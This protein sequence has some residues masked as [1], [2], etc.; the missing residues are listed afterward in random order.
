[1]QIRNP[2]TGE[3]DFELE[4]CSTELIHKKAALLRASQPEWERATVQ[5]RIAVLSDFAAALGDARATLIDALVT[6]TGRYHESVLEVD[7]VINNIKRWCGDAAVLLSMPPARAGQIPF[8][9]ITQSYLPYQ[10]VGV[11]S[12]WNFP[13]LLSMVDTIPALLAGCSVLLKPSEVTS[14]FVSPFRQVLASVPA[15]HRVFDVVTGTGETGQALIDTVDVTCFTGSVT[16]GRK[17]AQRCAQRFIPAFLELGGK[18]PAIVCEDADLDVAASALCW[19]SMVNAGQSCMS[20]ERV[21]VH[22]KV[23]EV[24]IE[25]LTNCVQNLKHN[26]PDVTAGHIG[27]IIS[28]AQIDIV[29]GQLADAKEKGAKV[30]CGGEVV[31]LGGGAYCQPTLLHNVTDEMKVLK[32]ETFAAILP[33][34]VVTSDAQAVQKANDTEYGL[35]AAVFSRNLDRAYSIASQLH[36]GAVSINDASLTALVH[37][38][39]KQSFKLSG[40]GGSRMGKDAIMR[41]VRKKAFIRNTGTPSPWWF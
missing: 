2:R 18:D 20:L 34:V 10:C 14:R 25:K 12:P 37:E 5:H 24:F 35:S 30:L 31:E 41:F 4:V 33:V 6:D 23:A 8:L 1:M 11:I 15:L 19:G 17:V 27:P 39:E 9:E 13:L 22:E 16:T 36:A 7:V 3:A 28:S 21:Y 32:E 29:K 40:M 26:F 38:A